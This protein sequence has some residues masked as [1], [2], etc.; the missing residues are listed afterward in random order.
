[1]VFP[2]SPYAQQ[3][4][5]RR[6]LGSAS[7]QR[8]KVRKTLAAITEDLDGDKVPT[9]HG[10]ADVSVDGPRGIGLGQAHSSAFPNASAPLAA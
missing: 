4:N 5:W 6:E 8:R 2:Y 3:L 1:L 9:V 10:G 7:N